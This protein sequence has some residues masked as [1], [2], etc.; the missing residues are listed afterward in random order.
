MHKVDYKVLYLDAVETDIAEAKQ[1]YAGQQEG[2]DARFAAA[3]KATLESIVKIPLSYAAR[4]KNVRI[5]HTRHF[6]YNIH[7]Y[8]DEG[9]KQVVI[10]GIVHNKRNDALF[11]DRR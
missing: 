11:L 1:W 8:V 10:T 7:F 9:K 6:P 2:L 5:A 4:Y 3:V